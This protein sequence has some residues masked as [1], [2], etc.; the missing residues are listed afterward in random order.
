L[1]AS[2]GETCLDRIWSQISR[3]NAKSSF[4]AGVFSDVAL[5]RVPT[6][7]IQAKLVS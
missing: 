1:A 3:F 2:L 4:P 6:D 5:S 7:R